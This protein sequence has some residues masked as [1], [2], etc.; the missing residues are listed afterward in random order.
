MAEKNEKPLHADHRARMQKRVEENGIESLAEHEALEY[1][2]FFAIP[3]KD[4]NALAHRLIQKFGSYCNVLDASEEEL[5]TVEGIGA[6]SARLLHSVMGFARYYS[7]A[8]RGKRPALDTPVARKRYVEPLFFGLSN[9][10]LYLI[11]MDDKY[12]PLRQ[13]RLAEGLPNKVTFDFSQAARAAVAAG[14]TC[15]MLAHNHPRGLA[16]PSRED[17]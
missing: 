17:L 16:I 10:A 6:G 11:P 8:K 3:R 5:K 2:L 9:E 1:L 4:T 13:V 14:A 15:A 12:Q 7:L